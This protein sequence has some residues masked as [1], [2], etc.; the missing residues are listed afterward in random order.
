MPKY[1]ATEKQVQDFKIR[2]K[3]FFN[4]NY[5]YIYPELLKQDQSLL[6]KD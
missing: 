4:S 1:P 2:S 6:K 3:K 5:L